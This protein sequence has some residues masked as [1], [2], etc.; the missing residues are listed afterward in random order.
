MRWD[1]IEPLLQQTAKSADA[2]VVNPLR[3]WILLPRQSRRTKKEKGWT[4]TGAIKNKQV[5]I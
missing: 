1:D 4:V 3:L 5:F 2:L